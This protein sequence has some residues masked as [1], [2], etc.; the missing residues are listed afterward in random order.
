MKANAA[1]AER[2]QCS[3]KVFDGVCRC[4]CRIPASVERGGKWYCGTHDP[5]R[6]AARRAKRNAA[7]ALER[8]REDSMLRLA[9]ARVKALGAGRPAWR[10]DFGL[11]GGVTLSAEDADRV[12]ARIRKLEAIARDNEP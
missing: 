8:E 3:E 9:E 1:N 5:E 10:S 6:V 12:I 11:S 4:F 7:Y 2:K